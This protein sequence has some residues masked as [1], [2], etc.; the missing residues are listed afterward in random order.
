MRLLQTLRAVEGEFG[1]GFVGDF[2]EKGSLP[3]VSQ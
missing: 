2:E 3:P 1:G